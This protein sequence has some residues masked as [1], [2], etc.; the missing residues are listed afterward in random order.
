MNSTELHSF[1]SFACYIPCL[2][3]LQRS[4]NFTINKIPLHF[5]K[6]RID[7]SDYSCNNTTSDPTVRHSDKNVFI[8][9]SKIIQ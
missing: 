6:V 7:F 1:L 8:T 2:D 5:N 3:T 4:R 9:E